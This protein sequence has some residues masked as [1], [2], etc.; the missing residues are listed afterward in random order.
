MCWG[1][2]G[3]A[4]AAANAAARKKPQWKG[5]QDSVTCPPE[6]LQSGSF[7]SNA[8]RILNVRGH[9]LSMEYGCLA[10]EPS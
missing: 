2:V 9:A 7:P 1:V 6:R 3:Q 5:K 4:A 10:I 8:Q